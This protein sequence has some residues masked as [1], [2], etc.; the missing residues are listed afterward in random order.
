[1]KDQLMKE[2]KQID[3]NKV[4]SEGK[5]RSALLLVARQLGC[6]GELQEMFVKYDNLLRGCTNEQES[7]HIK[8]IAIADINKLME[9]YYDLNYNTMNKKPVGDEGLIIK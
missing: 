9:T 6:A 7:K 5:T 2:P 4:A 1:M 3:P 8:M